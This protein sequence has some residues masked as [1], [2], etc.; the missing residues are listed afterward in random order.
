[1]NIKEEFRDLLERRYPTKFVDKRENIPVFSYRSDEKREQ[2]KYDKDFKVVD[3][4]TG[5]FAFGYQLLGAGGGEGLYRCIDS[6][7][8]ANLDRDQKNIILDAGCGVGR[9]IYDCAELFPR[10]FFVGM[11]F[12]YNMCKRARQILVEGRSIDLSKSLADTGFGKKLV[13]DRTKRLKNVMIAQGSVI[14]LP[15]RPESFDCVVNTYLI[16]RLPDPIQAIEEMA[17]VLKPKGLLILSDPLNFD[18][19]RAREKMRDV[20]DLVRIVERQ[21]IQI[22][23]KFDG[24]IYREVLDSRGN[25][26][27]WRSFVCF[28]QKKT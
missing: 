22:K 10:S 25:Y 27:D 5:L 21:G 6:L 19:P 1:M 18:K 11:D 17:R 2:D 14:K 3:R 20:N 16:D 9:T 23:E 4:Y 7:L 12:A 28:G 15:F 8:L 24:L 26:H 13:F